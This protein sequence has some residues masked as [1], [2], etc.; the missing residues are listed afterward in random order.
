MVAMLQHY[1]IPKAKKL[2]VDEVYARKRSRFYGESTE[3]KFFTVITDVETRKVIWVND[4]RS[5]E[6]LDQFYRIIG[7]EACANIEVFAMDQF[8]GYRASTE[9][10]CPQ[11]SVVLDRFHIRLFQNFL[12]EFFFVGL[13]K[14][15]EFF[16][17]F[18]ECRT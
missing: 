15:C 2:S 8:D 12:G 1:K 18:H 11:A 16:Q 14:L 4:G 3:K 5:K 9:E 6:A 17:L 7:K 10:H 13:R